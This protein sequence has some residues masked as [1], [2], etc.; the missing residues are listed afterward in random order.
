[1]PGELQDRDDEVPQGGHDLG[2][3]AGADLGGVFAVGDVA[4]VVQDFYAPVAAYPG[5]ELAGVA[6]VASRLVMA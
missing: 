5:G 4:D 3:G 2:A 1:M 6:S